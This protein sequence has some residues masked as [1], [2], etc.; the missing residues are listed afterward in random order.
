MR[1]DPV[2]GIVDCNIA[3]LRSGNVVGIALATVGRLDA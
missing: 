3:G 1:G 2:R